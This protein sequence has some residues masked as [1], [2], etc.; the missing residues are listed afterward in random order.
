MARKSPWQEFAENFQGVYG[1]FKEIGQDVETGRVMSDKF[2]S[3]GGLG[4]D[5]KAGKALEG[6]AL[7]KAR[8]KALGNIYT[9]Y[10]NA[11]E[12]LAMRQSVSNLESSERQ[13]ELNDRIFENQ[14][15][16][17]GI[18]AENEKRANIGLTTARTGNVNASTK[19]LL[20]TLPYDIGI[21]QNTEESGNQAN[22]FTAATQPKAIVAANATAD[23]TTAEAQSVTKVAKDPYSWLA[24]MMQNEAGYT[25]AATTVSLDGLTYLAES[26]KLSSL[27]KQYQADGAKADRSSYQIEAME[28]YRNDIESGKFSPD[29]EFNQE[30]ATSAF[31]QLTAAFEGQPAAT[32]LYNQ[33]VK[34]GNEAELGK[35]VNKGMILGGKVK[36]AL[37][38]E[39]LKGVETLF[40]AENGADFGMR[41]GEVE[42]D[43]G[44]MGIG[45]IETNKDG[46]DRRT[47]ASAAGQVELGAMLETMTGPSGMIGLAERLYQGEKRALDTKVTNA[48]LNNTEAKTEYQEIV[49]DTAKYTA[50]LK[51]D[52]LKSS[53]AL[54]QAQAEKLKQE[55]T[56][57]S[58]LTWNDK[59]AQ[60]AFNNFLGSS[61][62]GALAETFADDPAKLKLHT[63]RVK[64]GLGLMG[65]PPSGVTEEEWVAMSDADRALFN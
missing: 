11:K 32:A 44:T 17:Q 10:G 22:A 50:I 27:A 25:S 31:L 23:Q 9:K 5:A 30:A 19:E 15:R 48:G 61:T 40:D 24:P 38:S 64:F 65:K 18:L 21:L 45:L 49:N 41:L 47:I 54:A 51:Q 20:E 34:D 28:Q 56:Q 62:Y 58:G 29:G 7:D 53:T 59:A 60:K 4:Y 43:D 14:V 3:E 37:Q 16:L 8:Y 57:E 2:T 52:N 26:E 63:N 13:N 35:I 55:V 6:S 12:G 42:L 33:Y 39:G 46:T 36:N 1:T